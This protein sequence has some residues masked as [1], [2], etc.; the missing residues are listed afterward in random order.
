[1]NYLAGSSGGP[2]RPCEACGEPISIDG[3][4]PAVYGGGRFCSEK[5]SKLRDADKHMRWLIDNPE[6]HQAW[7]ER[8]QERDRSGMSREYDVPL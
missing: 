8:R 4:N 7:F 3:R 1:M 6:E 5:C 2:R